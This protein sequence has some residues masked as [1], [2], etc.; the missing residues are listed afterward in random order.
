[1]ELREEYK[2][3]AEVIEPS[4][5]QMERMKKNILEQVKAPQKKK[6]IPFGRIAAVGG[7]VA[8]CAVI[9]VAAV[10]LSSDADSSALATGSSNAAVMESYSRAEDISESIMADAAA[11]DE[12]PSYVM[13]DSAA[14][15]VQVNASSYSPESDNTSISYPVADG[16]TDKA[17]GEATENGN[18]DSVVTDKA[19]DNEEAAEVADEEIDDAPIFEAEDTVADVQ[20]NTAPG[21][22]T[23]PVIEFSDD[24]LECYTDDAK[25][26]LAKDD[27]NSTDTVG[28]AFEM[29]DG[30]GELYTVELNGDAMHIT[31]LSDSYFIGVYIK[32]Q[33]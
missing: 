5:A 25:Y 28:E 24:Y 9:A 2:K 16:S 4:E 6:P 32:V 17:I 23:L 13:S 31:R 30:L 14:A 11:A 15:D 10:R 8:A 12:E 27:L 21:T 19:P 18:A 3:C 20:T 22:D 33:E 7:S 26:V 1:M 29:Q